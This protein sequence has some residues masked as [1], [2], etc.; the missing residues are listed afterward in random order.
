MELGARLSRGI[1]NRHPASG[2]LEPFKRET[3]IGR[4]PNYPTHPQTLTAPLCE[5]APKTHRTARH[6]ASSPLSLACLAVT[7]HY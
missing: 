2:T 5:A 6:T 7:P 1:C 3:R 4:D